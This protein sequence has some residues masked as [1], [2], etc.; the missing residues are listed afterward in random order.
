M[1]NTGR[2]RKRAADN[3]PVVTPEKS[4]KVIK[5]ETKP[6][7]TPKTAATKVSPKAAKVVKKNGKKFYN[8]LK[9]K[10]NFF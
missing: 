5:E 1:K 10:I 6:V 8:V 3:Q 2:G 7:V 4:A 9:F